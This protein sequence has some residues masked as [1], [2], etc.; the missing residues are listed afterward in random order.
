MAATFNYSRTAAQIENARLL[1]KVDNVDTFDGWK[2]AGRFVRKGEKQRSFRVQ[3]GF[4]RVGINPITGEDQFEP[5][6]KI[7]YGFHVSQTEAYG[8]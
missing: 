5:V 4:R 3:A 7:A 2:A 6:F 8:R 1:E